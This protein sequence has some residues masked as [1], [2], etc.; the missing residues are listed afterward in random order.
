MKCQICNISE[1]TKHYNNGVCCERCDGYIKSRSNSD[2]VEAM[3][4]LASYLAFT[5]ESTIVS[6]SRTAKAAY[7]RDQKWIAGLE[8]KLGINQNNECCSGEKL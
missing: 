4:I 5:P 8:A 6:L 7:E 3:N 2:E 1:A